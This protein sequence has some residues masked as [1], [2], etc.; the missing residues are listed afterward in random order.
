MDHYVWNDQARAEREI[1]EHDAALRARYTIDRAK[2]IVAGFS[3]G[4][5]TAIWLALSGAV[6]ARGFIAVGPGG[7]LMTQP[8]LLRALAESS[9]GRNRRGYIVV[10]DQDT[11]S[12]EGSKAL[13]KSLTD[14]GVPCELEIHAG[15][16]MPSRPTSRKAWKKR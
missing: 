5:T 14:S 8:D 11:W 6:E 13:A 15:L 7:P 2:T 4:A 16:G 12:F 10:G 9:Q 3:M 1:R